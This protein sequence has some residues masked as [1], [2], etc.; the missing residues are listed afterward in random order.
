MNIGKTYYHGNLENCMKAFAS[1]FKNIVIDVA[2]NK[3]IQVPLHFANRSTFYEVIH[4]ENLQV[5]PNNTAPAMAYKMS[6]LGFASDRNMSVLNH[7]RNNTV[8]NHTVKDDLPYANIMYNKVPFDVDFELMIMA[9]R[10]EDLLRIIEQIVPN[11][12]PDLTVTIKPVK[13]FDTE[14]NITFNLTSVS[15][16]LDDYAES[17]ERRSVTGSMTFT[18][19]TYLF[20]DLRKVNLIK[21]VI[22]DIYTDESD[23]PVASQ[24]SSVI[25][26]TKDTLDQNIKFE[27]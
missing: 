7:I 11:F 1:M 2:D 8:K 12:A 14:Q 13:G 3:K 19:K 24:H 9:T 20:Q 10:V 6:S 23:E 27:D 18:A 17:D 22:V 4:A 25:D 21:E 15:I 26:V 16:E 5:Q